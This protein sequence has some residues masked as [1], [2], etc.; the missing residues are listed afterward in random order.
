[1][2]R[3]FARKS[4]RLSPRRRHVLGCL[5]AL[6][7]VTP[8]TLCVAQDPA[9][10]ARDSAPSQDSLPKT[11]TVRKG[12]TLWDLAQH[13]LR[14]PFLWPG[15]YRLNT[16]VVEDPHWIYPGEILRI[17]PADNIAAVPTMD[18]P[19]PEGAA[20]STTL[21]ADS[22]RGIADST[23]ALARGP[24]QPSL[25]ET[26]NTDPGVLFPERKPRSVSEI[27]KAYT[28]Q[29]YRPLRRSEF[30]S[31]GFLTENQKLPFGKVLGP[32]TPPQIRALA[33]NTNAMPYTTIAVSPPKGASYQVGD[34][35]LVV[36][37]GRE[38]RH[39]GDVVVPS[40]MVQITDTASG[41]YLARV[42]AVYGP[43]RAGQSVLPL[44][45]FSETG[46]AKATP[47]S[48]GVRAT[49]LGG[50]GRQ[51]LK[52][53]QMV[54]FLDK[55]RR[56][57]VA[58]GDLFEVRRRP[59]RLS[60]GSVRIDEVLATLQVVHVRERSATARLLTVVL[61]DIVPGSEAHQVAKLP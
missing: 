45:K 23:D 32:V 34:T 39:F 44:E 19:V 17:A 22:A 49:L 5:A 7:M 51:D 6:G 40:G 53:P 20:D 4:R 11:H 41:K 48:N 9:I 36:Q 35:L 3:K 26:E 31:S 55:G 13:Y 29:P 12:D 14:D 59:E 10:A 50:S 25:A 16:D 61:P 54:V 47:V 33:R 24:Q 28:H 8:T 43:I 2:Q 42:V 27:L 1:M 18:T 58:P 37:I 38:M 15:I 60:D 21:V 57:G 30:Y 56:D 52:V 46:S